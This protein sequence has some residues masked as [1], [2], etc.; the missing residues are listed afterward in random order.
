MPER[1]STTQKLL[2][3]LGPPYPTKGYIRDGLETCEA[4]LHKVEVLRRI[5]LKLR[6]DLPKDRAQL[7]EIGASQQHHSQEFAAICETIICELYS[8]LDGL[9]TFIYGAYRHVQRVQNESNERLL[10]RAADNVY[11]PG[12]P[13]EICAFLAGAYNT[14]FPHLRN[15]RKE[16][17]H[18][19]VGFCD[20]DQ[21][22]DLVRYFN[23]GIKE[24]GR[25]LITARC[26]ARM[27]IEENR[28]N[29]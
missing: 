29:K 9:R 24:E 15:L 28:E 2:G 16:L 14:W 6:P 27:T 7:E 11:G 4:H 8:V 13:E 25:T 19:S 10:K 20:L 26:C 12:I 5:A 21:T 1:W 18:G 23:E 3:F 22:T 17:T